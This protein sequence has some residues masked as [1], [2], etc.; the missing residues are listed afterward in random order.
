MRIPLSGLMLAIALVAH[1]RA[2]FV[3]TPASEAP[4]GPSAG[5]SHSPDPALDP[6][7]HK[8]TVAFQMAYGF[9]NR[10]PLAFAVRQIVPGWVRVSYGPGANP[11]SLVDWR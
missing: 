3:V 4:Q 1:S 6:G 8:S 7:L 9:G 10:I 2:D 11:R 5:K